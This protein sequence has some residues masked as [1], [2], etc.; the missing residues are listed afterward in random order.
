MPPKRVPKRKYPWQEKYEVQFGLRPVEHGPGSVVESADCMF[1]RCFGREVDASRE[2]KR[3]KTKAIQSFTKDRFNPGNIKKHIEEQHK[4]QWERYIKLRDGRRE[5]PDAFAAFF[6]QSKLEAFFFKES[7]VNGA[8]NYSID[9]VIVEDIVRDLLFEEDEVIAGDI[10]MRAFTKV[11]DANGEVLSYTVHIKHKRQFDHVVDLLAAGLSF[12]QISKVVRSDRENLGA[13]AKVGTL[14]PG[15]ASNYARL[16]AA[17]GLQALSEIMKVSWCF[18][19]G[20]DESN[21]ESGDPHLDS[22][23]RFPP[24]VGFEGGPRFECGFHLLAIP[25]FALAHTG[26]TY[27]E[28]VMKVL[29]ALCPEWPTKLIG[30]STDGAGN[31]SGHNSGFSTILRNA[32]KCPDAFYRVWCIAHQLDLVIKHAVSRI[33]DSGVFTF[34]KILTEVIGFLR[35]QKILIR[36]M[37]GRCP[38]YITTRWSSLIK[39]A[40][41]LLTN[42]V[43][44][45]TYM[46][47]KSFGHKPSQTW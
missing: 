35:R 1:C 34:M 26:Q 4:N 11:T 3:Q 46:E 6:G 44:V 21:D 30:S 27:A 14:S 5:D 43:R 33:D 42:R 39:V 19:I 12:R 32:S 15:E 24:V 17:I 41:W 8:V 31:M 16:A 7:D 13:A 45:S 18:S 28:L 2:R 22:R 29:N 38:Y 9:K 23:I 20:A 36:D 37:G 47:E 25:L 40:K 10:A